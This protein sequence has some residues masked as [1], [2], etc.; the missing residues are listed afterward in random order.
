M[1]H[2]KIITPNGL[3]N[4]YEASK[5]HCTT[6]EGECSL[7]PNH[8]PLVGM[9]EI[10]ALILTVE[11]KELIFAIAGGL[12]HLNDNQ[13]EILT[14]SCEG[15]AEI[16]LARATASKNRAEQRLAKKDSDTQIRRAEVSLQRALNRINIK[17]K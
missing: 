6:V 3:Y 8:M 7:L 14:D 1:L 15:A 11:N 12:L 5:I 10:S 17:S 2:V 9:L 16:D 13:V 4:T